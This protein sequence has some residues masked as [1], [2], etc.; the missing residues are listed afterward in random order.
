MHVVVGT[1]LSL[2]QINNS[3]LPMQAM[4]KELLIP[5]KKV[6]EGP[7][8]EMERPLPEQDHCSTPDVIITGFHPSKIGG[9]EIYYL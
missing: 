3:S 6:S 2:F 4:G 7:F 5:V 1:K 8:M 9:R